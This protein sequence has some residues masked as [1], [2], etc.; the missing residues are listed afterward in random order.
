[1][2][3]TFGR[4]VLLTLSDSQEPIEKHNKEIRAFFNFPDIVAEQKTGSLMCGLAM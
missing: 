1:M 3:T 2:I 4:H